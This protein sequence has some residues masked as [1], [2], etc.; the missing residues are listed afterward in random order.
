[1]R[2]EFV[3]VVVWVHLKIESLNGP[4]CIMKESRRMMRTLDGVTN[5]KKISSSHHCSFIINKLKKW[6]TKL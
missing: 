3:A 5:F 1:M 2:K 6:R 4:S